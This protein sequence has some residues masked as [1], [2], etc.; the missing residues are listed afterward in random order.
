MGAVAGTAA[1]GELTRLGGGTVSRAA[2]EP[3]LVVVEPLRLRIWVAVF[4]RAGGM[5]MMLDLGRCSV[6]DTIGN[7]KTHIQDITGIPPDQ[8]RLRLGNQ[9][10]EEDGRCLSFYRASG[11]LVDGAYPG[12]RCYY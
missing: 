10:L 4:P 9:L 8:Q 2:G 5:A 6:A 12:L 1:M 3:T 11:L 7:V